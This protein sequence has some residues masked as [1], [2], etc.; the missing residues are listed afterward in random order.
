MST[1]DA[2]DDGAAS[3]DDVPDLEIPTPLAP[4][5]VKELPSHP[6]VLDST[7]LDI[8]KRAVASISTSFERTAETHKTMA[9]AAATS[10]EAFREVIAAVDP[11]SASSGA[12]TTSSAPWVSTTYDTDTDTDTTP[13]ATMDDDK[14]YDTVTKTL[15]MPKLASAHYARYDR[16][17]YD[18]YPRTGEVSYENA[19]GSE[20]RWMGHRS[21]TY[22]TMPVSPG[23]K[24]DGLRDIKGFF[25]VVGVNQTMVA[26]SRSDRLVLHGYPSEARLSINTILDFRPY[27]K[28]AFL[29]AATRGKLFGQNIDSASVHIPSLTDRNI[30]TADTDGAWVSTLVNVEKLSST[31]NMLESAHQ[32]LSII[33]E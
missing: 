2:R 9:A 8:L 24:P 3:F 5:E 15:I 19:P 17:I 13:G 12:W 1:D 11:S 20:R 7:D 29:Y 26:N 16:Y 18:L 28:T 6:P 27:V 23:H 32:S 25:S 21:C 10:G 4:A 30:N 22:M 33:Q 31:E 14:I